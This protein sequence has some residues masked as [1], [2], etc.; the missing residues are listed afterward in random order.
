MPRI[1]VDGRRAPTRV[2]LAERGS[3]GSDPR[4]RARI[5][6]PLDGLEQGRGQAAGQE[7]RASRRSDTPASAPVDRPSAMAGTPLTSTQDMPVA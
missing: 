5:D 3:G 2:V 7:R 4:R 6:L 1:V